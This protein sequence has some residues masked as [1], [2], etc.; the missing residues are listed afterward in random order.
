MSEALDALLVDLAR[1]GPRQQRTVGDRL[2]ALL[3]E[4]PSL[5]ARLPSVASV[6]AAHQ[7]LL[8]D[9]HATALMRLSDAKRLNALVHALEPTLGARVVHSLGNL[10]E[11]TPFIDI[12]ASALASG[13]ADLRC[14]ALYFFGHW[15][16][17]G[18]EA[19]P[20]AALLIEATADDRK[21]T[22]YKKKVSTEA[23]VVLR[24][25]ML[26]S[27]NPEAFAPANAPPKAKGVL[28]KTPAAPK[29]ISAAV[30]M[31]FRDVESQKVALKML[32]QALSLD[33]KDVRPSF[34]ALP[35]LLKSEDDEVR[36]LST[37]L[38]ALAL[39][40]GADAPIRSA[41]IEAPLS[42]MR[43]DPDAEVRAHV[44]R[45]LDVLSRAR[46]HPVDEER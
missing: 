6:P 21:S 2:R 40:E 35:K 42:T 13:H 46:S 29:T 22:H 10:K 1:S 43:N 4:D 26:R 19:S 44:E 37:S 32:I 36:R 45:A 12:A 38:V 20:Y 39:D 7:I 27:S 25:A 16:A 34:D 33:M 14:A 24:A 9:L 5:Q 3:R 41:R 31:L 30:K 11:R 8:T 23:L 28:Q 17:S 15:V 18:G